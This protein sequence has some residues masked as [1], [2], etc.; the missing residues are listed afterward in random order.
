MCNENQDCRDQKR[1]DRERK[2][3]VVHVQSEVKGIYIYIC[4]Y[5]FYFIVTDK[6]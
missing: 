1:T 5:I 3:T 6:I 4:I 2:E